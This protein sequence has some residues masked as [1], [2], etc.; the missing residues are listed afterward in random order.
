M[1]A[2]SAVAEEFVYADTK[3]GI[4]QYESDTLM[5]DI[6]YKHEPA[7]NIS[8]FEVHVWC[9]PE[10]PLIAA[11]TNT[12]KPGATWKNPLW[13]ARTSKSVLAVNDDF[14]GYRAYNKETVG[15][16]IRDGRVIYTKTNSKSGVTLPNLDSI[17]LYSDGWAEVYECAEITAETLIDQGV[18]AVLTFGPILLRDGMINSK[19]EKHY[20]PR[21]PRVG[22][23]VVEPYH[24]AFVIAEGRYDKNNGVNL[25]WVAEKLKEMGAVNA[26]NLDGGNT[27]TLVFM[28]E[29]INTTNI[30][31]STSNI[32]NLS[33]MLIVG[34]SVLVPE[35]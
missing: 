35:Y 2:F 12:D 30:N 34:Y 13:I 4:W 19:L 27:S 3:N 1:L 28:G 8:W 21:E 31:G 25:Q 26:L 5:V 11:V 6:R 15:L 24:Y 17:A 7:G 29:K 33:S 18:T 23:G 22:F 10:T 32:R 20:R 14:F 9:S 16:I